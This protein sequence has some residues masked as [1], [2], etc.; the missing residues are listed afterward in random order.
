MVTKVAV[1]GCAGFI[2]SHLVDELLSRGVE[3]VGIDNFSSGSMS[4][5]TNAK[6]SDRFTLVEGDILSEE[7]LEEAFEDVDAVYH[8]AAN[9]DVR[10]GIKDTQTHLNQNVLGTV[11]VLEMMRKKRIKMI[12]FTSTSTVYGEASVLPT[13]EDYGPLIPIS[14]YGASKLGCEALISA[15]CHTFDMRALIFRFANVVG[16]RS[17]H[18]VIHD[19]ISKLRK[20]PSQ[21]EILGVPPGTLK[22]YTYISDC[23]R[24]MLHVEKTCAERVGIYNIGSKDML[25]VKS[26]AD[27]VC[28]EMGLKNVRYVWSGGVDGG[29]GWPGD[30]RKMHLSIEKITSEG[31]TPRMNSQESVRA[32]V[33]DLLRELSS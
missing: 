22:S 19:F 23:V 2:G 17:G 5:L 6:E 8:L 1:T 33:R 14:L 20:D 13:P 28:K 29:R 27:I 32:A 30:V 4:N 25:D 26:I 11:S 10:A 18:G 24:A 3:V 9:P 31:W 21:L 15:Y 16:S 12:S 7:N